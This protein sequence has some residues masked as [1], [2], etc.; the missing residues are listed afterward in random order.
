MGKRCCQGPGHS[1]PALVLCCSLLFP[2][3]K[4]CSRV[5]LTGGE[6]SAP[7]PAQAPGSLTS[8]LQAFQLIKAVSVLL[9]FSQEEENMLKETLEYKVGPEHCAQ[10][11]HMMF[12]WPATALTKG[13]F[14]WPL[15]Q[16]VYGELDPRALFSNAFAGPALSAISA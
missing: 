15:L 10:C 6:Q 3:T 16:R 13:C 14:V 5:S 12:H 2:S 7:L 4:T 11:S 1:D 8:V 9:N